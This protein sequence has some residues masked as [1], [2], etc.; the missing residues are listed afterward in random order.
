ME[1]PGYLVLGRL[2]RPHGVRGELKLL[3]AAAP[4]EPFAGLRRLWVG[5]PGG[6]YRPFDVEAAR[7]REP[8][9][10][11]KL[12]GVDSPED[13]ARLVGQEAAIPRAEAP[14]APEGQFYHYDILGLEVVQGERGLGAVREILETPAHDVYLV[15]GPAGEW[16]LPATRAHI[17]AIDL[18]AGRI[19]LSP[20][21]DVPGLLA[22]GEEAPEAL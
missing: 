21:A 13:A 14:P 12:G 11:L 5:P 2:V 16:M 8:A 17:A 19:E 7:G 9:V 20:E 22:G 6:P 1:R 4:W 3:L 18:A 10:L 15:Q